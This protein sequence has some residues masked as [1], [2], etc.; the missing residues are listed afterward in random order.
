MRAL[1]AVATY[2]RPEG[3]ARLLDSLARQDL[4]VGTSFRIV[5][6]DNDPA[7]SARAVVD[8]A[9]DVR[10]VHEPEPGIVAARNAALAL[11]E[12]TDEWVVFVDD[13]ER[14]DPRWFAELVRTAR[15]HGA[16]VV[17]G[18]VLPVLREDAPAWVRRGRFFDRPRYPTGT[19]A[20]HPATNN[21]IVRVEALM[22]LD[23]PRF[24][25]SYAMTGGSDSDLFARIADRGGPAIWCDTALVY[26]DVP[27]SRTNLKWIWR[28]N[29]RLGN[30]ASRVTLRGRP[31]LVVVALAVA[32]LAY[33]T[34]ATIVDLARF[35]G[36]R[37]Q[38][39]THIPKA[40]GMA[41]DALGS[42]IE[43]YRR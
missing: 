36:I 6:V 32:R 18:P 5:V 12:P 8:R 21:A 1:I 38:S 41:S 9:R 33:G 40:V 35:R 23:D 16:D 31:R 37:S 28:R 20:P 24:D 4:D 13:D 39:F 11:I 22:R 7:G 14:A 26:E 10:Y 3:L 42:R 15:Q 2:R 30:V 43:E 29:V 34:V 25:G 17:V 19:R 27:T